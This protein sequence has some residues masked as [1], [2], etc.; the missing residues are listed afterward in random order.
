[1]RCQT[2]WSRTIFIRKY[3]ENYWCTENYCLLDFMLFSTKLSPQK[4]RSCYISKLWRVIYQIY[5]WL[6]KKNRLDFLVH[7]KPEVFNTFPIFISFPT[8]NDTPIER[9]RTELSKY[10]Y[11]APIQFLFLC[12]SI[13]VCFSGLLSAINPIVLL[14]GTFP[15]WVGGNTNPR[16]YP[17]YTLIL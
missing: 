2:S 10:T 11:V 7:P 8:K 6:P 12:F 14:L 16:K 17:V 5:A 15:L 13:Y 3:L 1:M 4:Y 9:G